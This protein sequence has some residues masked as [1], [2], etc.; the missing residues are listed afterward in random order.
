MARSRT[1]RYGARPGSGRG[2]PIPGWFRWVLVVALVGIGAGAVTVLVGEAR[3]ADWSVAGPVW[4]AYVAGALA[5]AVLL[6]AVLHRFA[7]GFFRVYFFGGYLS[8]YLAWSLF[9]V[10]LTAMAGLQLAESV[11]CH[12]SDGVVVQASYVRTGYSSGRYGVGDRTSWIGEYTVDGTTHDLVIDDELDVFVRQVSMA[13][14]D[15]DITDE[16][17]VRSYEVAWVGSQHACARAGA[18]DFWRG[19]WI[20]VVAPWLALGPVLAG[21]ALRRRLRGTD[22]S[23]T[24][25][26]S[27][28]A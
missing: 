1:R 5:A 17:V 9:A 10:P 13:D 26:G 20:V 11:Q 28:T 23:G 3:T 7:T 18:S 19:F 21:L 4:A 24:P 6:A 14:P 8:L 12:R 22:E 2:G 16:S 25:A 15:G 27:Q